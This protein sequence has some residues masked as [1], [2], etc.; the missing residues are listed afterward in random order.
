MKIADTRGIMPILAKLNDTQEEVQA[1]VIDALVSFGK[2]RVVSAITGDLKNDIKP[3]FIGL[4]YLERA[5]E[6]KN[7]SIAKFAAQ[8]TQASI[9]LIKPD[10]STCLCSTCFT[11]FEPKYHQLSITNKIKCYVCMSC[12]KAGG[13]LFDVNEI[14]AVLNKEMEE[15]FIQLQGVIRVNWLKNRIMFD[16]DRI[17]ISSV[18]DQDVIELVEVIKSDSDEIRAKNRKKI[19]CSIKENVSLEPATLEMLRSAVGIVVTM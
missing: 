8:L 4:D 2:A 6:S 16:M 3:D 7:K 18:S 12:G 19:L 10:P 15:N 13:M 17:E 1:A 11:R 5:I 9:H 14:I